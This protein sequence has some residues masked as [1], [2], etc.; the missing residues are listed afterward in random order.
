MLKEPFLQLSGES[1]RQAINLRN[2]LLCE[3]NG[4]LLTFVSTTGAMIKRPCESEEQ[5]RTIFLDWVVAI[6]PEEFKATLQSQQGIV[7][8]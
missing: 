6:A 4:T 3:Q 2:I 7:L 8:G 5:A 1:P